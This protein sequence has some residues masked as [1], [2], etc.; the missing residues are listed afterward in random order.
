MYLILWHL[1]F[2]LG[3]ELRGTQIQNQDKTNVCFSEYYIVKEKPFG[4]SVSLLEL[5]LWHRTT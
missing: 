1:D 4:G 5:G 2:L 3:K